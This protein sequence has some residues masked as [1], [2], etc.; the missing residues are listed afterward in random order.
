MGNRLA[1]AKSRAKSPRSVGAEHKFDEQ[2]D[3]P[4][5]CVQQQRQPSTPRGPPF[6]P[7]DTTPTLLL[8]APPR[9]RSSSGSSTRHTSASRSSSLASSSSSSTSSL[10]TTQLQDLRIEDRSYLDQRFGP[11]TQVPVDHEAFP[12]VARFAGVCRDGRPVLLHGFGSKGAQQSNSGSTLERRAGASLNHDLQD[13]T[14]HDAQPRSELDRARAAFHRI[15][16]HVNFLSLIDAFITSPD[17]L[18]WEV[19]EAHSGPNLA[20]LVGCE[21]TLDEPQVRVIARSLLAALSVL[22]DRRLSHSKLHLGSVVL[23]GDPPIAKICD[24][25]FSRAQAHSAEFSCIDSNAFFLAPEV[26]SSDCQAPSNDVWAIGV[27]L[28]RLLSG[29]YPFAG[30]ALPMTFH[31]ITMLEP[32]FSSPPWTDR[33]DSAKHLIRN[34]LNK[35]DLS[36]WTANQALDAQWFDP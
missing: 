9:V 11:L 32:D 26:L 10:A 13:A 34:L 24:L 36:R 4:V 8:V 21:G 30:D 31:A 15:S 1:R 35:N 29:R 6:G 16:R 27:L 14:V 12:L 19:T 28:Y 7:A 18:Y 22:H 2:D 20:E 23:E 25:H 17:Q 33:S 5:G 3:H